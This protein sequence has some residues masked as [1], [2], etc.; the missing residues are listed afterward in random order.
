MVHSSYKSRHIVQSVTCMTPN[1]AVTYTSEL[2][3]GSTLVEIAKSYRK[4]KRETLFW[5]A[6]ASP[7]MI[8]YH[9]VSDWTYR[10]F[11]QQEASLPNKKQ[12]CATKLQ[13]PASIRGS[14]TM[15]FSDT[16]LPPTD[17]YQPK[18]FQ[19]CCCLVNLQAPF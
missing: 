2:Y 15:N 8:R 10:L 4:F 6:K 11:C 16:S 14:R 3:P 17:I 19:L 5:L 7:F 9:K 13:E 12:H 1:G 18:N